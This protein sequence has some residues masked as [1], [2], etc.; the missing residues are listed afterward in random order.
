[1]IVHLGNDV[2][3]EKEVNDEIDLRELLTAVWRGKWIIIIA[4]SIFAIFSV[5][6]ALSLPNVYKSEVLLAPATNNSGP[7]ISGQLGGL[8]ALAGVNIGGGRSDQT[9][10]AL[11]IIKSREFIGRFIQKH[12]LLVP[13]MAAEGWSL[14]TNSLIFNADLY[15]IDEERWIRKVKAPFQAQPSLLEA[16]RKFMDLLSLSQDKDNSLVTLSIEYYS[17]YLSKQWTN[18]L[19]EAIND[20]MRQRELHEAQSS[21]DYLNEQI[22]KINNS[23]AKTMLYSL[24]EEQTKT[25]MLANVRDEFVFKTL[26]PAVASERKSKPARA[27][28]C[29]SAVFIGGMLSTLFVLVKYFARKR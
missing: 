18:W 7:T 9:S 13:I 20:E 8:A 27:L 16:H 22:S 10:L 11:E 1:M 28:I 2:T 25:L 24:I 12:D 5:F 21:I 26:D 29:I 23:D 17:P 6:Y 4:T 14:E 15:D 19:V 3:S